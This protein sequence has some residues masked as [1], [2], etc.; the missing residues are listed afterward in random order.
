MTKT[1]TNLDLTEL[2]GAGISCEMA[3]S[4]GGRTGICP[5]CKNRRLCVNWKIKCKGRTPSVTGAG[6]GATSPGGGGKN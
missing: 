4:D 1:E 5:A 3:P 2:Q 6:A